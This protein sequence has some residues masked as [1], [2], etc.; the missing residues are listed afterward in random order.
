MVNRGLNRD[1]VTGALN[2]D[3]VQHSIS[4]DLDPNCLQ[5]LSAAL[6]RKEL[7]LLILSWGYD[8]YSAGLSEE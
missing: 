6:S 5:K 8:R 2:T 7:W 3:Q 1:S 4:P